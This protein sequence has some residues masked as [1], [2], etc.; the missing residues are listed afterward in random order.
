M[1]D[2]YSLGV[3]QLSALLQKKE[4]S[5]VELSTRMLARLGGNPH[6]AFLSV[7]SEVTLAQAK[8]AGLRCLSYT[9]NDEAAAAQLVA[10]GTEGIITDRVDHFRPDA[11]LAT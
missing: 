8:A 10:W 6:N 4:V 3:A 9:V 1:A 7:D 11:P 5:A 2:L